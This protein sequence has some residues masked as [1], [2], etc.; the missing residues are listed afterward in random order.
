MDFMKCSRGVG[1]P[2]K[3]RFG[4]PKLQKT[5]LN[6]QE[7]DTDSSVPTKKRG[8]PVGSKTKLNILQTEPPH[9]IQ[10]F[11]MRER[12]ELAATVSFNVET[13]KCNICEF[14]FDHHLKTHISKTQ[15]D[16]C[17]QPYH[18]PCLRKSGCIDCF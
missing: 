18:E 17:Q 6:L 11:T 10:K 3:K 5:K 4:A 16:T 8:R 7:H 12:A 2:K 1:R 15:C 9:K 13:R 14:S